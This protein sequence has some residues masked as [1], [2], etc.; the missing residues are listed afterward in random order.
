MLLMILGIT[1]VV[2]LL[3]GMNIGLL[4]PLLESLESGDS[5]GGHWVSR[6][7]ARVFDVFGLT[8]NLNTILIVLAGMVVLNAGLKY[9][10]TI[11]EVKTSVG[12]VIWLRSR[13]MENYLRADVSYFHSEELGRMSNTLITQTGRAASTFSV[14]IE[15]LTGSCVAFAYLIAAFFISPVLTIVALG[16]L[17]A[18][19]LAMQFFISR[20][21]V[22]GKQVV[23]AYSD[24]EADGIENLSGIQV[25]KS[26]ILERARSA[27]FDENVRW[28]CIRRLPAGR[29]CERTWVGLSWW[30]IFPRCAATSPRTLG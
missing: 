25:I 1:V 9:F 8:L 17:A 2:A 6:A 24:L 18:L 21:A 22:M 11:L 3:E 28:P 12:F 13:V 4:V 27:K 20:A 5:G 7:L 30:P 10:K 14:I 23:Q 15:I 19:T 29:S 26:F 16:T